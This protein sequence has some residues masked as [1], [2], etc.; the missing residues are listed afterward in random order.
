[1]KTNAVTLALLAAISLA[2][3]SGPALAGAEPALPAPVASALAEHTDLCTDV[4]G[5]PDASEAVRKVDLNGDGRPEFVLFVGWIYCEGAVS[6]Y[7]QRT[8]P[9]SIHAGDAAGGA[10]HVFADQVYDVKV[11]GAGEAAR[12]WLTVSGSVCGASPAPDFA[13]ESFCER[14]IEWSEEQQGFAYAPVSSV[15]PVQ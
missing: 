4:G 1:M 13:H 15:R 7:G 10:T 8:R 3:R 2:C 11:E 5:T 12:L 9:V 14:A 6:V